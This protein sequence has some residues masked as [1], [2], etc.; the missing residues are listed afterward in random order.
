MAVR[1]VAITVPGGRRAR[2]SGFEPARARGFAILEVSMASLLL[3]ISI[4]GIT[5][6]FSVGQGL[7]LG[8]GDNRVS[9]FLAQQRLEQIRSLG[10]E[11]ALPTDPTN[12]LCYGDPTQ[13]PPCT[14]T[15]PNIDENPVS[16]H[17]GYRRRTSIVCPRS[18]NYSLL[19]LSSGAPC[20][21]GT[22]LC[23]PDYNTR[24][25]VVT[26]ENVPNPSDPVVDK[27]TRAITLRTVLVRRCNPAPTLMTC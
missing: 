12:N 11:N 9:L 24:M 1:H 27:A 18:D 4:V 26:V 7:I 6:M 23:P 25:V 10:F 5:L 15:A 17:P 13:F 22:Q 8:E 19:C 2:T 20:P 16:T 21:T 3:G 14:L